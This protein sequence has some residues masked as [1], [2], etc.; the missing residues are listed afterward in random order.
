MPGD[1][2]IFLTGQ[3]ECEEAV[4]QLAEESRRLAGSRLR[5]KLLPVALY[6]GLAAGGQQRVFQPSP[7]GLR[8]VV[9]ATNV[10]ETSLTLEGAGLLNGMLFSRPIENVARV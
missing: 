8:K 7:R 4:R 10:A 5:D 9:A 3:E 6:A 1:I 2:L